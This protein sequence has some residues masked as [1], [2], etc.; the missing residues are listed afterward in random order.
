MRLLFLVL[1]AL[2]LSS[3][4]AFG[5]I[6][7]PSAAPASTQPDLNSPAELIRLSALMNRLTYAQVRPWHL[8]ATYEVMDS[9]GH[10]VEHGTYDVF[11]G[12]PQKYKEVYASKH[13][14]QTTYM[15][16]HGAF[17]TGE[18]LGAFGA[19]RLLVS[20]IFVHLPND[21][22]LQA[23]SQ[24]MSPI[25]LDGV[26]LRC[27]EISMK[28]PQTTVRTVPNTYCLDANN[29]SLRYERS[30]GSTSAELSGATWFN[31]VTLFHDHFVARDINVTY[32]DK[33]YLHAHV[34]VLEDLGT[35][36]D[37]D[38]QP[39]PNASPTQTGRP[40]VSDT[41]MKA[42]IIKRVSPKDVRVSGVNPNG[43]VVLSIVVGKDGH[44]L[45]VK[46]VSGLKDLQDDVIK[47]VSQWVYQPVMV[48]N[49]PVEVETEIIEQFG[50]K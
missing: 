36:N 18:M 38:F 43:L 44:V 35:V 20:K 24:Q 5:Q 26:S 13:F 12:G 22:V 1:S 7:L 27:I 42:R 25:T 31:Q 3:S 45:A 29:L 4:P 48:N 21:A 39:P 40:V 16:D 2:F 28:A 30:V 41:A 15:T 46:P 50:A 9:D 47:A 23:T 34:D 6:T 32:F 8:R 19:D 33:P 17:R 49:E 10:K 14:S 37:A 11:F